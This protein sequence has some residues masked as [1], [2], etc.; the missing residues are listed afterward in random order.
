MRA[1]ECD[2]A[3]GDVVNV[4]SGFEIAIG[5]TAQLIAELMHRGDV[6]IVADD[7]RMRPVDSEVER[8]WADTEKAGS[9]LGHRP[10]YAGLDGLRRGL[11]E[12]IEWFTQPSNLAGHDPHR[13]AI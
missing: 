3:I 2:A 6:Q 1:A 11:G 13:Y 5:A 4:G 8:L 7:Q 9:L 12:T 10:R